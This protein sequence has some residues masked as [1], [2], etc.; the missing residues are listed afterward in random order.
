[1][2]RDAIILTREPNPSKSRLRK[3]HGTVVAVLRE[4]AFRAK[5]EQK[6]SSASA[7]SFAVLE[8]CKIPLSKAPLE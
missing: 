2:N 8:T 7:D 1:M 6:A 5:Q 3:T 4:A